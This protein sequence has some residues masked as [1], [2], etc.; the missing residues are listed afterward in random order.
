[1][2]EATN[3]RAENKP[4]LLSLF[5]EELEGLVLSLGQPKYRAKQIFTQ[6]AK[7]TSPE[8]M[9]ALPKDFR[10]KLGECCEFR[11]PRVVRKLV[12]QIDGT[13]KYLFRLLDGA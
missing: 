8:E 4:D 13:V 11:L 1:M 5:P 7:G 6:L 3:F 10:A 9:T 2:N 12:S